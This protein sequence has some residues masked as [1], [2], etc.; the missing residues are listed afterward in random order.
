[1]TF[2]PDDMSLLKRR[3]AYCSGPG[4]HDRLQH[5]RIGILEMELLAE[6]YQPL[7]A[8]DLAI[9]DFD[10]AVEGRTDGLRR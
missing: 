3:M 8:N 7:L 5:V 4:L 6:K 1:M 10:A 2:T 9:N